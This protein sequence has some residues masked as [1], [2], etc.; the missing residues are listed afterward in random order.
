MPRLTQILEDHHSRC[1]DSFAAAE[2]AVQGKRWQE[3]T[4]HYQAFH[5][6]ME[7]HFSAEETLLFPTFE[8]ATGESGGPTQVM[9]GEHTQMRALLAAMAEAIEARDADEYAGQAETLLIMMQQHNLKEENILYPM[10]DSAI[11]PAD[12]QRLMNE[13]QQALR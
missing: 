9:R 10:C 12:G 2:A 5:A 3:A 8:S 1:D 4:A 6:G 7:S 13:I 11:P